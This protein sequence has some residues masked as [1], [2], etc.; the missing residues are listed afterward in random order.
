M[1]KPVSL[2]GFFCLVFNSSV[3]SFAVMWLVCSLIFFSCVFFISWPVSL[4][5][6]SLSVEFNRSVFWHMPIPWSLQA[7]FSEPEQTY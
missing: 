1:G 7:A 2:R 3:S 4:A 6:R 5:Y